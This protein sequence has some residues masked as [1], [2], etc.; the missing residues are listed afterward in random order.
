MI[1]NT[2]WVPAVSVALAADS[3]SVAEVEPAGTMLLG[4]HDAVTPGGSPATLSDT[5]PTSELVRFTV[6]G[7]SVAFPAPIEIAV[8]TFTEKPT[9]AGSTVTSRLTL[10]VAPSASAERETRWVPSGMVDGALS[11]RA[12]SSLL[13]VG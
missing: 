9:G 7:K 5:S 6:T 11:V 1:C 12:H 13:E 10:W 8:G 4:V 3:V 2:D